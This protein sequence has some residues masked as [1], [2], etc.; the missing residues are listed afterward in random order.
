MTSD[1]GYLAAF[2]G[3]VVS[4]L[5]PCVLPIVPA[6]LTVITGLDVEQLRDADRPLVRIGRDTLLFIAG[7]SAVFVGLGLSATTSAKAC[8]ATRASSPACPAG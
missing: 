8:S 1:V 3:G 7:F 6:Y 4:F 2:A 5:S